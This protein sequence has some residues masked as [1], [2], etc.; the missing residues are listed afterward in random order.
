MLAEFPM[1][2]VNVADLVNTYE[3]TLN[4][5][6]PTLSIPSQVLTLNPVWS[7]CAAPL[8]AFY[9]PPYALSQGNGFATIA[10]VTSSAVPVAAAAADM[11]SATIT[12]LPTSTAPSATPTAAS[13]SSHIEVQSV[14]IIT[15][16]E[17]VASST[18]DGSSGDPASSPV[19]V[20]SDPGTSAAVAPGTQLSNT[21][22]NVP[23]TSGLSSS[24]Q[25]PPQ[26]TNSQAPV[27]VSSPSAAVLNFGSSAI[28][29]DASSNLVIASQTLTPGGGVT[30]SGTHVSLAS[31]GAYVVLDGESTQSL[32]TATAAATPQ[33]A[34]LSLGSS[35]ITADVSSNLVFASQTLTPGGGV[36]VSGTQVS[37]ASNGAY[38]VINGQSTQS[39]VTATAQA[40][41]LTIGS[42]AVTADKSSNFIIGSQTLT[43]G[44]AA[45]VSGTTISLASNG[46]YIILDAQSTQSLLTSTPPAAV[47][48]VGSSAITADKS[49]N[50]IIGSQTLTAGGAVTVSGTTLSLASNG[51]YVVVNGQTQV[52]TTATPASALEYI[53]SS[54]TLRPNGP[55]ITVAGTVMSLLPGAAS[56]L[57]GS[58]TVAVGA[59]V[60]ATTT[61]APLGNAI[62]SVGGFAPAQAT[63]TGSGSSSPN[64][65][66]FLGSAER[67]KIP[68]R[69]WVVE[70]LIG[71]G[72]LGLILL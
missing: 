24:I 49:S 19:P 36:T 65:T 25:D 3:W 11:A 17:S 23:V 7:N 48:T 33:A 40:A 52:L 37:L 47:L 58:Q 28:T 43:A 42:S 41:V 6:K 50:F 59:L 69:I 51:A 62:I 53:I 27:T 72:V 15:P 12:S 1:S 45:T 18:S 21:G 61:A 71:L 44:G 56:V 70:L 9:D 68:R 66:L 14:K 2:G 30:I 38:V 16:A 34:V 5:C 8:T 22:E 29:A 55:A 13:P 64:G 67:N 20:A 63:G 60:G 46:A 54:Q 10:P 4:P 35:A 31:N 26:D 32:G 39:L 57:V